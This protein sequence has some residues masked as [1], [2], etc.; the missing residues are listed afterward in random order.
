M[1]RAD[2]RNTEKKSGAFTSTLAGKIILYGVVPLVACLLLG[3]GLYLCLRRKR[4]SRRPRFRN[5][6]AESIIVRPDWEKRAST[7]TAQSGPSVEEVF[8]SYDEGR[9]QR[10]SD[11]WISPTAPSS[12]SHSS[13]HT[14][15]SR[16]LPALP[17]GQSVSGSPTTEE[18]TGG[19]W[20]R[21]LRSLL[22][23]SYARSS[24]SQ[25]PRRQ[26]N[27]PAYSPGHNGTH[28]T[29]SSEGYT[30]AENEKAAQLRYVAAIDHPATAGPSNVQRESTVAPSEFMSVYGQPPSERRESAMTAYTHVQSMINPPLSRSPSMP[31]R[32]TVNTNVRYASPASAVSSV[33][34]TSAEPLLNQV[35]PEARNNGKRSVAG[36]SGVSNEG[37]AARPDSDIIPFEAF[38]GAVRFDSS[39]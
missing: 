13:P 22:G 21:P 7:W 18:G 1:Y 39:K 31:L 35:W 17:E 16:T 32:P 11:R 29:T 36:M 9:S 14:L 2:D 25:S 27:L 10:L 5:S 19:S 4:R 34:A 20:S 23:T 15:S 28:F 24:T 8:V 37:S 38:M 26:T 3:L 12:V 30:S 33:Q 6:R